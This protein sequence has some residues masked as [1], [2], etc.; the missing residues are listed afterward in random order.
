MKLRH[1][2]DR[3]GNIPGMMSEEKGKIL[4]IIVDVCL[5]LA[6]PLNNC[7]LLRDN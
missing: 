7:I 6:L 2:L 1:L 4:E 5:L 3:L